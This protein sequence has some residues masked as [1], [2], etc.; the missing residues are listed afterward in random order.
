MKKFAVIVLFG[1]MGTLALSVGC[2]DSDAADD[3]PYDYRPRESDAGLQR[4]QASVDRAVIVVLESEPP[5]YRL[6]IEGTLP[7]P[8]HAWRAVVRPPD[9]THRIKVEVYSV[10]DPDV[11]C[12]QV[13]ENFR[14]VVDLPTPPPGRYTVMVN[15]RNAGSLE[16]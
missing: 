3:K 13:I 7:T 11:M 15:G 8:C 16:R 9:S 1:F 5:Q 4:G 14:G 2:D 6:E 10:V 12:I